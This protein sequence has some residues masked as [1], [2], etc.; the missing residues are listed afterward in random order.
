[1]KCI[2]IYSRI[3]YS[4]QS[5]MHMR[6]VAFLSC[7]QFWWSFLGSIRIEEKLIVY[8]FF[9]ALI[10]NQTKSDAKIH[11]YFPY[12]SL[13]QQWRHMD[14][15]ARRNDSDSSGSWEELK[16]LSIKSWVG[17]W[18]ASINYILGSF[19]YIILDIIWR[20]SPQFSC[21]AMVSH[22]CEYQMWREIKL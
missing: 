3:R 9:L 18:H 22:R 15:H 7:W 13:R 19:S 21:R 8:A 11:P 4:D 12:S 10:I 17:L 20:D 2:I 16:V 1:M 14:G 6:V 5:G